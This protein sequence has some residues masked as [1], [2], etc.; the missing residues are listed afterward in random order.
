V[1]HAPAGGVKLGFRVFGSGGKQYRIRFEVRRSKFDVENP[2]FYLNLNL[3]V[4]QSHLFEHGPRERAFRIGQVVRQSV[5]VG[6]GDHQ[7]F[8]V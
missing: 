8:A 2:A 6:A 4:L 1:S 7:V 3:N 5:V